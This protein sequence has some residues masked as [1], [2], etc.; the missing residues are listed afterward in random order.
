MP[1]AINLAHEKT[2]DPRWVQNLTQT[3]AQRVCG[4][5]RVAHARERHKQS[6]SIDTPK[7]TTNMTT[8]HI[9]ASN[10]TKAITLNVHLMMSKIQPQFQCLNDHRSLPNDAK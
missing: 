2:H 3:H 1:A 4:F 7:Y 9:I 10:S 5:L 6:T 8:V